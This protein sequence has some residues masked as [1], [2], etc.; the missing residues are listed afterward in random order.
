MPRTL[1]IALVALGV[2]CTARG[3]DRDSM[4]FRYPS[5]PGPSPRWLGGPGDSV[6]VRGRIARAP[7]LPVRAESPGAIPSDAEILQGGAIGGS[8][9]AL[10]ML[11]LGRT[12][13]ESRGAVPLDPTRPDVGGGGTSPPFGLE[14][15]SWAF[16]GWSFGTLAGTQVGSGSRGDFL[17]NQLVVAWV[18]AAGLEL[19]SETGKEGLFIPMAAIQ[20]ALSSHVAAVTAQGSPPRGRQR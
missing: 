1:L 5:L 15:S 6:L 19:V 16:V 7:L 18:T 12:Q 2:A 20:I 11:F 17:V 10:G 13:R 9:G 3:E 14:A 8:L 4:E